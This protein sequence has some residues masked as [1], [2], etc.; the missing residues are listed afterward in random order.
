MNYD[1]NDLSC[2]KCGSYET[3]K[4][5]STSALSGEVPSGGKSV[6]SASITCAA[7]GYFMFDMVNVFFLQVVGIG[8][9]I[10][11]V[12]SF[13]SA[14]FSGNLSAGYDV[15]FCKRCGNQFKK[16][17]SASERV[18]SIPKF[19]EKIINKIKEWIAKFAKGETPDEVEK[20]YEFSDKISHYL[21]YLLYF[22]VVVMYYSGAEK[23]FQS[24]VAGIIALIIS[25]FILKIVSSKIK[26]NTYRAYFL[27]FLLFV[28]YV[29]FAPKWFL[30]H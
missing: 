22:T 13:L 24:T 25:I 20:L 27:I 10:L 1:D 29:L 6:F 9:L 11:G 30:C 4:V 12:V 19:F 28:E 8:M 5:E 17:Y 14:M 26:D 2:P 7:F 18:P 23:F 16:H 21:C 3:R 15:Y